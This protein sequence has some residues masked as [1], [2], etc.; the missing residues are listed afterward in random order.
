MLWQLVTI[1]FPIFSIVLL[2][3]L[4]GRKHTP[5]MAAANKLNI[6]V[7]VPALIFDVMTAKSFDLAAYQSLTVAGIAVVLGSAILAWPVARIFGFQMKTFLPPMMFNNSGNM[8]LPLMLFAF[9]EKALPAAVVLFLIENTLH[10]SVGTKIINSSYSLLALFK[11]PMLLAT[12]AAIFV[13]L[14]EWQVPQLLA[15]PIKMLGQ[16]SIP[17]MLFALGVRLIHIDWRDWKIG[18]VGAIIS[19]LSGLIIAIPLGYLLALPA[20]QQAMLI[21]FSALPPAVL[22]YMIA[23]RYNQQPKQVASIVMLGNMSSIVI[24]PLVLA[25]VL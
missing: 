14:I 1:V 4:Y 18:A 20:Q 9:G 10:F 24:I 13:S 5:D 21:V 11:I 12:C 17:L 23:E 25:F 6:D 2:G 3:F 8:G 19:P 15:V 7:F 16:I 22:N